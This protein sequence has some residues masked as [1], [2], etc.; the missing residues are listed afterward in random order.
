M[1]RVQ[2]LLEAARLF[3]LLLLFNEEGFFYPELV[4]LLS[5]EFLI[6]CLSA[7]QETW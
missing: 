7:I 2:G 5:S 3:P 4:T 6:P 1:L